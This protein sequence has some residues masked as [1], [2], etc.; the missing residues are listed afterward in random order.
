M[1]SLCLKGNPNKRPAFTDSL[2]YVVE[3]KVVVAETTSWYCLAKTLGV[4]AKKVER[5]KVNPTVPIGM[6]DHVIESSVKTVAAF[7]GHD[8]SF[9]EDE[10][11]MTHNGIKVGGHL[12]R[13]P[14]NPHAYPRLVIEVLNSLDHH[15]TPHKL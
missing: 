11:E 13:A 14:V 12:V 15:Q 6:G 5:T 1:Q 4:V 8:A 10:I 9:V 2:G 7:Y 3:D